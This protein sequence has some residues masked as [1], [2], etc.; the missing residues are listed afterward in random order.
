MVRGALLQNMLGVNAFLP[1][2][3]LAISREGSSK[4]G[5]AACHLHK[6]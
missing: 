3:G 2:L 6:T 5:V 1:F 4:L